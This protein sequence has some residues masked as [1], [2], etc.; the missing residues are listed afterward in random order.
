MSLTILEEI[1]VSEENIKQAEKQFLEAKALEEKL[2][3]RRNDGTLLYE[4]WRGSQDYRQ[5]RTSQLELQKWQCAY[6]GKL[7]KPGKITYLS[8]GNFILE[9]DHP[10]VEHILPKS[11]F[12]ELALDKQNLL[13]VCSDCNK[14][15]SNNMAEASRCRHQQLKQK[16]L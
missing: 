6:C 4:G 14:R 11:F 3:Q 8:N 2:R 10:T 13:M 7:M 9:P 5:W 15:K 16:L 12:P 1:L